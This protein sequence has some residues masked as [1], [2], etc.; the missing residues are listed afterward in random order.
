MIEI[1]FWFEKTPVQFRCFFIVFLMD[2]TCKEGSNAMFKTVL[3][4]VPTSMMRY[5]RMCVDHLSLSTPLSTV[6]D[7]QTLL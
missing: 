5:L 7:K 6:G 1:F 4:L 2:F 3:Q